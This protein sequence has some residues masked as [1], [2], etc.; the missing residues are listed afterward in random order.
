[1]TDAPAVSQPRTVSGDG[2]G[3]PL[4]ESLLAPLLDAAASTLAR[5]DGEI[6]TVLR[7]LTGFD[8]K[9]LRSGPARQ[10]LRRALEVD[11]SFRA[12]VAERFVDRPEV[13]AVL[14]E[15]SA[16]GAVRRVDDAM[17]RSDLELLASALFAARPEAW[18]FGLGLACS[19]FD[20]QRRE[21]ERDDDAKARDTQLATL[22]EARR[23]VENAR[24]AAMRDVE[25][26]ESELRDERKARRER[27]Q[28]AEREV[29]AAA[30]RRQDAEEATARAE[31]SVADAAARAQRASD[32]A[33]EAEAQL[34]ALRRERAA[35]PEP[36][37]APRAAMSDDE[38]RALGEVARDAERLA[39]RLQTLTGRAGAAAPTS[40]APPTRASN[41]VRPVCPP[42]MRADTAD[43]LDAMLRTRGVQLVVDGYNVS[44]AGWHDD[45]PA[46][47]RDRL[48]GALERLHLRLRADVIVVF[49]GA[50]VQRTTAPRRTG[51]RVIFT[52]AGEPADPVVIR[53]VERL[54]TTTPAIVASSDKWVREHAEAA[55]ATVVPAA[56]LLEVL[57]R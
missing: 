27:E 13:A 30:R 28:K 5:Y 40:G 36:R 20:R 46:V 4:S 57:R 56:A 34:R 33:R 22:D 16:E 35:V 44:M 17:E 6:P 7:P 23:R 41:R 10:Q 24:D 32:R 8:P 26:L 39:A 31:A 38:V 37:P 48:L 21:K 25:R 15:W 12:R 55:G 11:P 51:V 18:E 1:V 47:Q 3:L 43:A 29:E 14:D 53:E 49:D 9:R 50:D 54:P 19:A 45:E 52:P 42:G 2:V